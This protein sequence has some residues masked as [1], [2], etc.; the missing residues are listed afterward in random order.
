MNRPP[1]RLVARGPVAVDQNP[2][3]W[4]TD[5]DHVVG[6]EV[7]IGEV[8]FRFLPEQAEAFTPGAAYAIYYADFGQPRLSFL[9][10][11]RA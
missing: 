3:N 11:E 9:S 7:S 1:Q 10:A 2:Y 5:G 4:L 6:W 8:K